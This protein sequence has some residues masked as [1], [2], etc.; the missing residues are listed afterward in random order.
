MSR[1]RKNGWYELRGYIRG[2]VW[3]NGIRRH[4]FQHRYIMEKILGRLIL[5]HEDVHH[6]DGNKKNN[7]PSNLAILTHTA[8]ASLTNKERAKVKSKKASS[9][10]FGVKKWLRGKHL[11]W[12]TA[13]KFNKKFQYGGNFKNEIDAAKRY[14]EM[15]QKLGIKS[16]N[17]GDSK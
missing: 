6:I 13:F 9:R 15:A 4:V 16:L 1:I 5:P 8:H 10:Y 3:E 12:I 17:F 2:Y 14:D 11:Y 7:S